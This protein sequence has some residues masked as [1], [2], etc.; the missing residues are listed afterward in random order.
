MDGAVGVYDSVGRRD[1]FSFLKKSQASSASSRVQVA[2]AGLCGGE[3]VDRQRSL[4]LCARS[5]RLADLR[6]HEISS[7]GLPK[8]I[9]TLTMNNAVTAFIAVTDSFQ[10]CKLVPRVRTAIEQR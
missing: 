5:A 10:E 4:V 3:G 2:C 7:E 9:G 6:R 8:Q 1:R